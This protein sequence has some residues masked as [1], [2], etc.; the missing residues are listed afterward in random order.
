MGLTLINPALYQRAEKL[1]QEQSTAITD[2]LNVA[3]R[4][5][6]WELDRRKIAEE[7]ACYRQQHS[8]LCDQYL[9]YYIAMHNGEVVDHD[10]DFKQLHARVQ[11]HWPDTAVMI[12]LVTK[13]AMPTLERRGFRME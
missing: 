11:Q 13:Q 5:Y 2:I 12:T 8:Q 6:F 9:G 7:S 10:K 1:A 4:Q 3:L